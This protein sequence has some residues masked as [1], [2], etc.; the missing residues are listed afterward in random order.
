VPDKKLKRGKTDRKKVAA[1]QVY[2]LRDLAE[3]F[4]VRKERIREAIAIVGNERDA[5]KR[6]IK[7][8]GP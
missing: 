4:G 1:G 7:T 3:K 8:H 6:F 5:I 2:E